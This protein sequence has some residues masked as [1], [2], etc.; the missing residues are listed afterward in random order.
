MFFPHAIS[1]ATSKR[2][3]GSDV[4]VFPDQ[5]EKLKA[6]ERARLDAAEKALTREMARDKTE[7]TPV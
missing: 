4:N 3:A 5:Q 2:L 1:V 7:F 6:K